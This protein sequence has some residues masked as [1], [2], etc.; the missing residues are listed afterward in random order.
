MEQPW[1]S[2]GTIGKYYTYCKCR[3]VKLR[4]CGQCHTKRPN[5][6]HWFPDHI[7][8]CGVR[9]FATCCVCS[10]LLSCIDIS[11]LELHRTPLMYLFILTHSNNM[12]GPA[13]YKLE[14]DLAQRSSLRRSAMSE[15]SP[16][17]IFD[18]WL[19]LSEGVFNVFHFARYLT[20]A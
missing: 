6:E 19:S 4:Q 12:Q 8:I 13:Q 17:D 5:S 15:S 11:A 16:F 2:A 10:P 3:Y 20:T 9:S 7:S 14:W 1:M 18:E